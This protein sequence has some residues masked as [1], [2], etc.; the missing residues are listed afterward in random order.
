MFDN[1]TVVHLHNGILLGHK[2]GNLTFHDSMDE[3][4]DYY[5]GE[6]NQSKKDKQYHMTSLLCGI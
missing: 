3:P 6:I 5:L 1:I 2:K 4:G